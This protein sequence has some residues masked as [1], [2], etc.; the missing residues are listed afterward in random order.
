[1][2]ADTNVKATNPNYG[3]RLNKCNILSFVVFFNT[4]Q[5]P[6]CS[7]ALCNKVFDT[8]TFTQTNPSWK[9]LPRGN[10]NP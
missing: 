4:F 2:L 5:L 6:L 10:L 9:H 7:S 1:M 8:F 3:S